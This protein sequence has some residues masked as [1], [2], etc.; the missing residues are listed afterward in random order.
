[1]QRKGEYVKEE[2]GW[3]PCIMAKCFVVFSVSPYGRV[4]P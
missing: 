2:L 4:M 1:M 3:I